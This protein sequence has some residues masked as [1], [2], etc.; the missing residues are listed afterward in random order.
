MSYE[1]TTFDVMVKG[2]KKGEAFD[3]NPIYVSTDEQCKARLETLKSKLTLTDSQVSLLDLCLA[4]VSAKDG[5]TVAF[6]PGEIIALSELAQSHPDSAAEIMACSHHLTA[7]VDYDGELPPNIY[8]EAALAYGELSNIM[9]AALK[10]VPISQ[11][12]DIPDDDSEEELTDDD[13]EED[14]NDGK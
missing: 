11:D 9:S 3:V 7:S 13:E 4:V 2:E 8:L 6:G 1:S 12:T 14:F 5:D 10:S